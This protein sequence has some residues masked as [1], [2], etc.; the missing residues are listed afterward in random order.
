VPKAWLSPWIEFPLVVFAISVCRD[1]LDLRN[2]APAKPIDVNF[3]LISILL[4]FV[5][6]DDVAL[7]KPWALVQNP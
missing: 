1:I 2:R 4:N 7:D 6:L 5:V 3:S